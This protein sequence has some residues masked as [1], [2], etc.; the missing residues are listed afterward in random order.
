MT[1]AI[2]EKAQTISP[3]KTAYISAPISMDTT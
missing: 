3:P 1:E 2:V